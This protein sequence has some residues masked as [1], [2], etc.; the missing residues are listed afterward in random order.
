[1]FKSI[2]RAPP[3][4]APQSSGS[5]HISSILSPVHSFTSFNP[6]LA[7]LPRDRFPSS[8]SCKMVFA[9]P[10]SLHTFIYSAPK[11]TMCVFL[12]EFMTYEYKIMNFMRYKKVLLLEHNFLK[13]ISIE[14]VKESMTNEDGIFRLPF[15]MPRRRR[16]S[17]SRILGRQTLNCSVC[18]AIPVVRIAP[19]HCCPA[20]TDLA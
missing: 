19:V 2:M 9:S 10:G 5:L 8:L 17:H 1:M 4:Q 16:G 15:P 6:C 18:Q 13:T 20:I 14:T 12:F 3:L 11:F 7:D